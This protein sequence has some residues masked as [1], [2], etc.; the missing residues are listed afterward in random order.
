MSPPPVFLSWSKI[1]I[2]KNR[3]GERERMNEPSQARAHTHST[4][5]CGH[6]DVMF[7]HRV[8]L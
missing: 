4:L 2:K 5:A 3:S 8:E 1:Y 6:E 7:D